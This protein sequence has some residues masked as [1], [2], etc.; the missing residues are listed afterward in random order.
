M[1]FALTDEQRALRDTARAWLAARTSDMDGD[2]WSWLYRLGWLD[3]GLGMVELAVLAEEAGAALLPGPWFATIGLAAPA[4]LAAGRWPDR[5]ATVAW[6]EPAPD[7]AGRAAIRQASPGGPATLTEAA[8]GV[9]CRAAHIGGAARLSGVKQWVP[10]AVADAVVVARGPDGVA[11]YRVDLI[12]IPRAVRHLDTMDHSR[13]LAELRLT[14]TGARPLVGPDRTPAVLEQ[15]HRRAA[16]LLAAEAVGVAQRALDTAVE[17]AKTRTQFGRAIGGYQGVAHRLADTA[18]AVEL[19]RS[20]AYRAAWCV[21][22]STPD[23]REAV[24]LASVAAREAALLSCAAAVQTLGGIGFAWEHPV[25]RLFRRA[26][27]I[28]CFDGTPA[29]YRAEL[30]ASV[31][32]GEP[33][34]LV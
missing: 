9:G 4:Y 22:E 30:G 32:V 23:T 3:D 1:D 5:P 11:L 17:Y 31:L 14:G 16:A 10:D 20:L 12:A 27:W 8:A 13:P 7:S 24:A 28:A 26:S 2:L 19:A 29:S 18:V 6:A 21:Q 15:M 25:H 33:N 34:P